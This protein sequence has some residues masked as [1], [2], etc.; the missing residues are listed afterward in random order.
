M[1]QDPLYNARDAA[2][3]EAV[4][5]GLIFDCFG[6]NFPLLSLLRAAGVTD[7]VFQGTGILRPF[8]YD[9]ANGAS[10]V[11]GAT[12]TP[13]RKQM[14]TDA[15]FD[16]RFYQSNLPVE[17]TVNKLFN[18]PGSTQIFSQEDL[19]TYALTK[20]LESMINMD[21]YR[22]GQPSA[23]NPG[24]SAGVADDRHTCSNGFDEGLNNGIDP[25][26][27]GNSYLYYG[28]I[29]RNGVVGQSYNSTPYWC[30]TPN[31]AAGSITFPI[32]QG[33]LAQL[34]VIGAKAKVGMT[35]PFGWGAMAVMF[36]TS[37]WIKQ[38]EVTEGT[39]FGWRSVD[40]GGFKVHED[41][42]APSSISYRYLPGGNPGAYGT[43]S[44]AKFLDGAGSNTKLTP[45]LAPTYQVNG[46]N[47]AVGTLS[48]TGSNIPSATT[49]DP[50]EAL[51]IFDPEAME[52][53]P[54]KPGSGWNFDTRLVQI[55]DNVSTD[56][57]FLKLATNVV[58]NQPEHGIIIY[59]FKGVRG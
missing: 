54:P 16:I 47:V 45:F 26:P 7:T 23:G 36:R 52:L 19:D 13:T 57:R 25:S 10:T 30:G 53:L 18:A 46:A 8:I 56:N 58:I 42:L 1:P 2:S 11:P 59:G 24:G 40:F 21:G 29:L 12:I 51:Y 32:L 20:K 35:S 5:L 50:A 34:S 31:G 43:V 48:P 33:A 49:I 6:T 38:S 44:A 55:P 22:H 14:A 39:D 27:F 9:Y 3:R 37:S 17:Q 28:S 4:T 15:K 41:P